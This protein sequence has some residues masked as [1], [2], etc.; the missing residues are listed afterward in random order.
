MAGLVWLLL[1][2]QFGITAELIY[3]LVAACASCLRCF[4][5]IASSGCMAT[6]R[7]CSSG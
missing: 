3:K 4:P 7:I 1:R 2:V 6:G 5:Y